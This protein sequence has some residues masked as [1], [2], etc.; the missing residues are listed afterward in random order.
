[1]YSSPPMHHRLNAGDIDS[2]NPKSRNRDKNNQKTQSL[3]PAHSHTYIYTKDH[4]YQIRKSYDK[5]KHRGLQGWENPRKE[6][7]SFFG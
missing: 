2:R 5:D 6:Q 1:M 7:T 3:S 4:Y